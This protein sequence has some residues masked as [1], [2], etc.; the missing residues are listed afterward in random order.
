MSSANILTKMI[1]GS[2][3]ASIWTRMFRLGLAFVAA[4]FI[5]A[6]FI[7]VT[8]IGLSRLGMSPGEATYVGLLLGMLL[9]CG[10]VVWV[11]ATKYLARI[12]VALIGMLIALNVLNGQ[13]LVSGV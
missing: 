11:A 1:P 12:S 2:K 13:V 3:W 6:A 8:G 9:F 5:T 10:L 7:S 4:Y